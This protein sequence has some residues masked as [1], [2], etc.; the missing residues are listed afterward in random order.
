MQMY[1]KDAY[2]LR[3]FPEIWESLTKDRRDELHLRLLNAKVMKAPNTLRYWSL[4]KTAP[5]SPVIK[6]EIARVVG[7]FLGKKINYATL[8]PSR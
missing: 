1:E 5:A 2:D 3:S 6:K 7:N 8:F 4:G